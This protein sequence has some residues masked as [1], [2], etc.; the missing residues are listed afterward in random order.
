MGQNLSIEPVTEA[1]FEKGCT[2]LASDAE[3]DNTDRQR[4]HAAV[5]LAEGG[6]IVAFVKKVENA[7]R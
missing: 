3:L 7:P 4:F 1:D 5:G 6:R 2:E